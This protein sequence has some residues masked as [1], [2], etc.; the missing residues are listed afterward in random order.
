MR[1]SFHEACNVTNERQS[2][3]E[4]RMVCGIAEEWGKLTHQPHGLILI[5]QNQYQR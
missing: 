3:T 1:D 2:L 4:L 5:Q